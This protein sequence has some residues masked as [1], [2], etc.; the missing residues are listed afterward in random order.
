MGDRASIRR[1]GPEVV[2]ALAGVLLVGGCAATASTGA[3]PEPRSSLLAGLAGPTWTLVTVT[4]PGRAPMDVRAVG[5]SIRLD[6]QTATGAD[7]CV[8]PITGT[9]HGSA[10]RYVTIRDTVAPAMGCVG[11]TT[12]EVAAR[13]AM[14]ALFNGIA[15]AVGVKHREL[16]LTSGS[17]RLTFVR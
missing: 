11:E 1:R 9:A 8:Q 4:E 14:G 10:D 12:T 16:T 2:G 6:G 15:F 7:G 5:A 13:T 3:S 17:Y